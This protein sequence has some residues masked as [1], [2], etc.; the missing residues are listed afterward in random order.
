VAVVCATLVLVAGCGSSNNSGGS[1]AST[2]SG[3][4]TTAKASTKDAASG[5]LKYDTTPKY[6]SPASSAPVQSGVVQI[7]YSNIA[8][9][10]DAVKAKVGSTAKWTNDD[11]EKCNVTSEGGPYK[12]ASGDIGEGASF[13][14]K[15]DKPGVIHYECTYYPA[16]M[17]GT[18]E[19]VE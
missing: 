13:E 18:V 15:L 17:N 3:G 16:T 5:G 4:S 2:G 8:I 7:T 9:D 10:P 19:V 1:G 12:F 14:L 6:A 11:P